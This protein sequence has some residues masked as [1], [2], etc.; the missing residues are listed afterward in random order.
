MRMVLDLLT[1]REDGYNVNKQA[2]QEGIY[3]INSYWM[4][5]EKIGFV[6]IS[7][8]IPKD[9]NRTLFSIVGKSIKE[10]CTKPVTAKYLK[11]ELHDLKS[12]YRREWRSNERTNWVIDETLDDGKYQPL[13]YYLGILKTIT[14][15]DIRQLAIRVFDCSKLNLYIYGEQPDETDE[16]LLDILK[17]DH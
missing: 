4:R 5:M 10:I 2:R 1:G 13:E 16:E 14:P 7:S 15:E 12:I 17:C 3:S 11:K 8:Y 6:V 9:K